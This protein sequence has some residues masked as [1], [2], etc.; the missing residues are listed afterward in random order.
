MGTILFLDDDKSRHET[1]RKRNINSP[2]V[3]TYVWT[4]QEACQAL[5]KNPK[6]DAWSLDH[7]LG[8][9]T[10]VDH[11]ESNTG[12]SLCRWIAEHLPY[13]KYPS[14]VVIHSWN[15]AGAERMQDILQGAGI[16]AVRQT[17]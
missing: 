4:E 15:P 3:I 17:F 8:G 9:R 1:F 16:V 10:Y 13:D 5:L 11:R 7:D 12:S 14:Q 2:H 6:F